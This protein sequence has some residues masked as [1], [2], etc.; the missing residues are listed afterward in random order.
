MKKI[1]FELEVYTYQID[2]VG[3]LSNIV[4]VEWMEIGRLKFLEAVGLPVTDL[5]ADDIYPILV[6]T[7]ISYKQPVFYGDKILCEVWLSKLNAAS[8]IIEFRFYK[9]NGILV[10]SGNQKG[11]F[12]IGSTGK[13]YRLPVADR[14][15][16]ENYLGKPE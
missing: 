5:A 9:N 7:N 12:I 1:E 2:I 3:H 13:P 16:F 8:A 11:L 15:L 6:Q 10:A 4:Y 14:K